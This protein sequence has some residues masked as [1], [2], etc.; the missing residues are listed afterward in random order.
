MQQLILDWVRN[1]NILDLEKMHF[2]ETDILRFCRA[3]KFDEAKVKTMIRNFAEWYENENIE[4]LLYTWEFPEKAALQA[5]LP[6][7]FHK[8]DK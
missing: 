7:G 5:A 8:H 3:R 2:N 6:H 1:E 4:N